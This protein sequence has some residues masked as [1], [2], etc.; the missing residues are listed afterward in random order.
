MTQATGTGSVDDP[1]AY[2]VYSWERDFIETRVGPQIMS[3]EQCEGTVRRAAA[4][5]R[6][7]VPTIRYVPH[8][9][10]PC[11][12]I[13]SEHELRIAIWGRAH[14]TLLHEMAHLGSWRYVLRGEAPHG[15]SFVGCA[16]ELYEKFLGIP[17]TYMEEKA[18]MRGIDF[19]PSM[20][21]SLGVPPTE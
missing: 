6:M 21:P 1:Q 10:L 5:L 8:F 7:T 2:A 18:A 15:P 19:I 13:P 16:I 11:L 17:S 14:V 12:A 9:G 20:R 3:R 4:H